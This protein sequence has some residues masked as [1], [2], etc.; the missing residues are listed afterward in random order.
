MGD[1]LLDIDTPNLCKFHSAKEWPKMGF[2]DPAFARV[3]WRG[4]SCLLMLQ[5]SL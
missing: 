2:H 4:Q 5:E 1:V 3:R